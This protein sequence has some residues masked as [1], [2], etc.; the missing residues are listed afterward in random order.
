MEVLTDTE[1][2]EGCLMLANGKLVAVLV[3]LSDPAHEPPLLGSWYL[4]AGLGA[5]LDMRHDLFATLEG[6][7]H[8]QCRT[9]E[10]AREG[11]VLIHG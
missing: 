8:D 5:A 7:A 9:D 4:E 3:R 11:G 2:H 6:A 10:A 1:D